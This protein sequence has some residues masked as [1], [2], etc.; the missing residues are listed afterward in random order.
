MVSEAATIPPNDPKPPPLPDP[1]Y[2]SPQSVKHVWTALTGSWQIANIKKKNR[3]KNAN[4]ESL[5]ESIQN[6]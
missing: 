2:P 6:R 1:D 5:E 3:N 4:V